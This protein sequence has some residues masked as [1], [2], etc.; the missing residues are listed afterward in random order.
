MHGYKILFK[1][2][3]LKIDF[4]FLTSL[5]TKVSKTTSA[6]KRI[7]IN[8]INTC[9]HKLFPVESYFS[10]S[11]ISSRPMLF[12]VFGR[13]GIAGI[14]NDF[15]EN[16]QEICIIC[17]KK[18]YG[19]SLLCGTT[20]EQADQELHGYTSTCTSKLVQRSSRR[21]VLMECTY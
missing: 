10:F 5:V 7:I 14:R 2:L 8:L 11:Y 1:V 3:C 6:F 16:T 9:N 13:T 21:T 12:N 19:L 20:K 15:F 18:K 4:F 17:I